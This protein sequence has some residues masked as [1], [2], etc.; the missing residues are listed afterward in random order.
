MEVPGGVLRLGSGRYKGCLG[1][2]FAT[3]AEQEVKAGTGMLHRSRGAVWG[4]EVLGRT[5][6]PRAQQG[7]LCS[8]W[9]Q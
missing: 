2:W 6:K 9:G 5:A 7:S 8:G 1:H 4:A 3:G